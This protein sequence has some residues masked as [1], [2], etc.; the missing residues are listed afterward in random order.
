M[1]N[2][3]AWAETN[4]VYRAYHD[5]EWGVPKY[6]SRD[7][8][9]KLVLD[10]FQAGLSWMTILKK[11]QNFRDAFAGFSPGLIS[12]WGQDEL[13]KLMMN[14]GIVRNRSKIE[15][16]ISNARAYLEIESK[17]GFNNF[18]WDYFDG[19]VVQNNWTRQAEIPTTDARSEQISKDLKK[20][21]FKYCGPTIVYAFLEASGFMNN[22]LI[23]CYRHDEVKAIARK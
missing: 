4:S 17:Q 10:G 1:K 6:D 2:R 23:S 22:H 8:W 15:A 7:L 9:E 18:L 12:G 21:G 14:P 5:E 19:E 3:C 11:R 16:T 20:A 13:Q